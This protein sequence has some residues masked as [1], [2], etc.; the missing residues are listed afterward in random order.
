MF[1]TKRDDT[2]VRT[3]E[4]KYGIDVNARGD[5]TLGNLLD[6]RGFDSQTQ[7]LTAFR[8]QATSLARRRRLFLSFHAEDKPQVQGFRLMAY[9]ENI[10]LDFYDGSLQ[11]PI[12]SERAPYV[13]SVL[14]PMIQRA[15]VVVCLI[16]DGTAWREWVDWELRTAA[17]MHKGICGI[18]LKHSRGRA[19]SFLNEVGAPVAQWDMQQIIAAIECAA[20]RRS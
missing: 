8:G 10:D 14:R 7:F 5:M 17:E 2:L 1:R 9:N 11:E 16:G 13:K 15:S 20:A 19:P 18:R 6:E 4:A 12:N 3:I